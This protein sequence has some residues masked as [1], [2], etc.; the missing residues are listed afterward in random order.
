MRT[1]MAPLDLPP[2]GVVSPRSD[3]PLVLHGV[4]ERL[5]WMI[6]T[7]LHSTKLG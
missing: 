1:E 6:E 5:S 4:E 2:A 3:L 7:E